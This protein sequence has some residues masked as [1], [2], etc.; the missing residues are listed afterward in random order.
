MALGSKIA[1]KGISL[2]IGIPVGIVTKKAVERAWLAARP[3]DPPRKPSEPDVRWTDALG[4]A[5]V[6]AVG[7]VL[8]ELITQTSAKAAFK[9]I[10]GNEPPADPVK[11]EDE[12]PKKA[13]AKAKA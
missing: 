3:E 13:K 4:W 2:V 6:S 5:A 11:D 10:T 8:A 12:K 9:A 1:I 7:I